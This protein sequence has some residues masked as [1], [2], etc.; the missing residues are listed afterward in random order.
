MSSQQLQRGLSL[1][2]ISRVKSLNNISVATLSFPNFLFICSLIIITRISSG[3]YC[4]ILHSLSWRSVPFNEGLA[5]IQSRRQHQSE[6]CISA[7]ASKPHTVFTRW[8]VFPRRYCR[9]RSVQ[10]T[11]LQYTHSRVDFSRSWMALLPTSMSLLVCFPP[12]FCNYAKSPSLSVILLHARQPPVLPLNHLCSL[13]HPINTVS[14]KTQWYCAICEQLTL[15]TLF[16]NL[17]WRVSGAA[18]IPHEM[19]RRRSLGFASSVWGLRATSMPRVGWGCWEF[20]PLF[21]SP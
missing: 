11:P 1:V 16:K 15:K 4:N 6:G 13:T 5:H 19:I 14:T 10:P 21:L 12:I 2:L 17:P 18:W 8:G 20:D 7:S 9:P 3:G